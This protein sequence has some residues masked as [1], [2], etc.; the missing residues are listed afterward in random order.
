MRSLLFSE[1][2]EHI[3]FT[4]IGYPTEGSHL[5]PVPPG[6]PNT[7]VLPSQQPQE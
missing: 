1:I 4:V 2:V 3:Q 5:E 6:I 7:A